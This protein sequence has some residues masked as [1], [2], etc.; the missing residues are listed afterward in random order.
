V[1]ANP[2]QK[3]S[4]QFAFPASP[5]VF[6][7]TYAKGTTIFRQG[8]IDSELYIV[9]EGS[10]G[11]FLVH[12]HKTEMVAALGPG[13]TFGEF[14]LLGQKKRSAA[15]RA[16]TDVTVYKVTEKGYNELLSQLPEWAVC[17][18]KNFVKQIHTLEKSK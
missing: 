4:E 7:K 12:N 2:L 6:K 8:D 14:A 5:D 18:L 17:M 16:L 9:A 10:V 11:I 15:A 3:S 1:S 13:A